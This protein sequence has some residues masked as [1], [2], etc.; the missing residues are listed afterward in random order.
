MA[1]EL[2]ELAC[3]WFADLKDLSN[4]GD[5]E[6]AIVADRSTRTCGIIGFEL[7]HDGIIP[8]VVS[9]SSSSKFG[10][11]EE[12]GGRLSTYSLLF[13]ASVPARMIIAP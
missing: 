10:D 12:E 9:S 6:Q 2:H 5:A 4:I 7:S 8:F 1:A 11:G 13:V 3:L